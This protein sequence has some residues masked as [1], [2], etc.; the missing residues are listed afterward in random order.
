MDKT[1]KLF[2]HDVYMRECESKVLSVIADPEEIKAIGGLDIDGSV[3]LV[4]DRTVFF[5]EGGGQTCDTGYIMTESPVIHVFE[6]DG[7][8]YHQAEISPKDLTG[9][10]C[11][12][13]SGLTDKVI[14]CRLDWHKRFSNMQRHCG[15]HILSAVLY[16]LYGG[17]NRGFHMGSDYMTIDINLETD[18]SYTELSDE[19]MSIAELEANKMIWDNL[20]VSTRFFEKRE[21]AEHLPMRK[22]LSIEEDIILVCVGDESKPSGCVACCG[23]HPST[24]GQV[25]LIKLYKWESYKGMTRITFD[26]GENALRYCIDTSETVKKLSK[27]YSA[28]T[29][30]LIEKIEAQ[31]QRGK[32][33][34]QELYELKKT[35]ID[36]CAAE[37]LNTAENTESNEPGRNKSARNNVIVR[38]YPNLKSDDLLTL[39]KQL[40][41][42]VPRLF[43]LISPKENTVILIRGGGNCDCGKIVK[44][45]AHIWRGKGGGR[46]D[47]ARALFPSR[48]D[49]DCFIDYLGKAY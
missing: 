29:E 12:R 21:D 23:T 18:P 43:A 31:E 41:G 42:T 30:S 3:C 17:V 44:D 25:G 49:L 15:E 2:Q 34:R 36:E 10:N 45:N 7:T 5:P 46:A 38:E 35:Y 16:D 9:A 39:S 37:I 48:Q 13:A 14:K 19:M 11:D 24:T 4:L 47:N 26:A 20:P 40:Y 22:Q 8:V 33:I 32:E 1:I 6:K 27:R 28:D